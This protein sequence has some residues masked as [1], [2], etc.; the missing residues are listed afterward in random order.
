MPTLIYTVTKHYGR[1]SNSEKIGHSRKNDELW[2]KKPD[3][4]HTRADSSSLLFLSMGI[5]LFIR[6]FNWD[7]K[8]KKEK[9]GKET[10]T[11]PL[12]SLRKHLEMLNLWPIRSWKLAVT[13]NHL[14]SCYLLFS[15]NGQADTL[16]VSMD[17]VALACLPPLWNCTFHFPYCFLMSSH[18]TL[19]MT[20]LQKQ[21]I[22]EL[23]STVARI[24][25]E[26]HPR[27]LTLSKSLLS[28]E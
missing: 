14:C 22:L 18:S 9:K 20:L 17:P 5:S 24:G 25:F 16:A 26:A 15:M 19:K 12:Y 4:C 28:S 27:S 23:F 2:L 3:L 21:M 7:W 11:N 13:N 10:Q 1:C 8:W 6:I